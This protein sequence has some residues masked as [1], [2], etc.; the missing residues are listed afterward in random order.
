MKTQL[1]LLGLIGAIAAMTSSANA[2]FQVDW[3]GCNCPPGTVKTLLAGYDFDNIPAGMYGSVPPSY[4]SPLIAAGDIS[5]PGTIKVGTP[6][7]STSGQW[8]CFGGFD[9]SG[10]VGSIGFKIEYT[11]QEMACFCGLTFDVFSEGSGEFEH[12]PTSLAVKIWANGQAVWLSESITLTPGFNNFVHWDIDNPDGNNLNGD[13]FDLAGNF[14][15]LKLSAGDTL[16]FEILGSGANSKLVGLDLDNVQ[17]IG[18]A[19]VPEPSGAVLL[20]SV[21][22]LCILRRRRLR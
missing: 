1:K 22:V 13:G 6:A 14:D 17:V 3:P 15:W 8:G 21:G 12:G 11:A 20:G 2:A 9:P 19:P 16:A 18:C 7:G 4:Q 5:G 10:A